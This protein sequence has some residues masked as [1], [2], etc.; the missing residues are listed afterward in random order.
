MARRLKVIYIYIHREP[1]SIKYDILR[2][3]KN[4]YLAIVCFATAAEHVRPIIPKDTFASDFSRQRR[5]SNSSFSVSLLSLAAPL[6]A[7]GELKSTRGRLTS[8][9]QYEFIYYIKFY[10]HTYFFRKGER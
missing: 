1:K 3:H 6:H 7:V 9:R 5:A 4:E 10:V 2:A 8:A